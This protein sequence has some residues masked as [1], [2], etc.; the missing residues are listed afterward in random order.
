M[1]NNFKIILDFIEFDAVFSNWCINQ[2]VHFQV[3]EFQ[4]PSGH[5]TMLFQAMEKST[6]KELVD[7]FY[8]DEFLYTLIEKIN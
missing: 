3:E 8:E 5:P 7:N 1:K 4:G 6:L 2:K